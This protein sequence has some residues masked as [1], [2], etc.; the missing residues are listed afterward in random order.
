MTNNV[1]TIKRIRDRASSHAEA[2]AQMFDSPEIDDYLFWGGEPTGVDRLITILDA[3]ADSLVPGNQFYIKFGHSGFR[4]EFRDPWEHSRNQV[5]HFLTAVGLSFNSGKVSY[6]VGWRRIRDW[7]GAPPAWSDEEVAI[8]LCIGH[9]KVADPSSKRAVLRTFRAQFAA[10]TA[11]DIQ[12]F[13]RAGGI[14]GSGNRLLLHAALT[15]LKLIRVNDALPGNSYADLLLTLY[16]WRLG[17]MVG[18]E[19]FQTAAG[20]AAWIRENISD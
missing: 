14:L 11:A 18:N 5:G 19:E 1:E 6:S 20:I 3:T 16:G 10:T 13:K 12:A 8:R 4:K 17:K 7:V 9:E 15:A 2:L